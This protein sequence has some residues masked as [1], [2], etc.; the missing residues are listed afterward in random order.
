MKTTIAL[1]TILLAACAPGTPPMEPRD[2]Q[3]SASSAPA[4][5]DTCHAAGGL[6]K[7]VGR[8]QTLQCVLSYADAG[9]SCTSGSQCAGDC[10]TEAGTEVVPGRAVAGYCQATSDRF[11]CSTQVENG[12]AQSTICID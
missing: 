8:R 6:M 9:K 3:S 11:G 10:R 7:P 1:A 5:A 4:D 2:V 12:R